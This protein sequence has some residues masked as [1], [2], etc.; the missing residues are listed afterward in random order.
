MLGQQHSCGLF[1]GNPRTRLSSYYVLS[2]S[3][4]KPVSY[5]SCHHL[6]K[7]NRLQIFHFMRWTKFN[8]RGVA[9]IMLLKAIKYIW[10]T[11][12]SKLAVWPLKSCEQI[13]KN[14]YQLGTCAWS[15]CD[16][17][18]TQLFALSSKC[19]DFTC[20]NAMF[21]LVTVSTY[22]DSQVIDPKPESNSSRIL[23]SSFSSL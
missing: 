14:F 10:A 17:R 4:S 1:L 16:P 20:V 6:K 21:T 8:K 2:S 23:N 13:P 9:P 7:W 22:I 15:S 12:Y 19:V 5:Q 18:R 3:Y 11:Y